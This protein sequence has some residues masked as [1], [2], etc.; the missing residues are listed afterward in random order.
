MNERYRADGADGYFD[1]PRGA[2]WAKHPGN[3]RFPH[4][5]T[6]RRRDG[7][8]PVGRS[9]REEVSYLPEGR[10]DVIVVT[11]ADIFG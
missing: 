3:P 7:R 5:R 8:L 2:E 10:S 4:S 9:R 6:V 11:A 1:T